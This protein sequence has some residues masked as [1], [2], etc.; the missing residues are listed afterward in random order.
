MSRAPRASPAGLGGSRSRDAGPVKRAEFVR[1]LPA[2]DHE[3]VAG[4]RPSKHEARRHV[5]I[6]ETSFVPRHRE[7]GVGGRAEDLPPAWH[8]VDPG[9][10]MILAANLPIAL[11]RASSDWKP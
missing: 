3:P 10:L 7:I 4:Q 2:H 5:A 1:W 11:D 6:A 8:P 9:A